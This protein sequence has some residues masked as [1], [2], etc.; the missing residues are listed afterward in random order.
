VP[1]DRPIVWL[2]LTGHRCC[3]RSSRRPGPTAG[4]EAAAAAGRSDPAL[5]PERA[6]AAAGLAELA[7]WTV[8][9]VV[10]GQT[11]VERLRGVLQGYGL[12]PRRCVAGR[13]AGAARAER[14][15]DAV[16]IAV[17]E[18]SEGF[19]SAADRVMVLAEADIFGKATRR[20]QSRRRTGLASLSQLGVGDYVVHLTH[21]VGRYSGCSS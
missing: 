5:A 11:Q 16:Q 21:G 7:P 20:A 12:E 8:L 1:R 13:G 19:A 6:D 15:G 4:G 2:T 14:R 9:L 18:L 17:G 10:P 3:A